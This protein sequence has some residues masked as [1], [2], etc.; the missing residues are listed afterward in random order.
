[1]IIRNFINENNFFVIFNIRIIPFLLLCNVRIVNKASETGIGGPNEGLFFL[2]RPARLFSNSSYT[3]A[4]SLLRSN[5]LSWKNWK[6]DRCKLWNEKSVSLNSNFI[7]QEDSVEV[8]R[9]FLL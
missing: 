7:I 6:Q 8:Q 5:I 9:T 4:L 1:M 3:Y 2:C